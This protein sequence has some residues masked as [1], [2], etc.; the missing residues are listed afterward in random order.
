MASLI[1]WS[2]CLKC[3]GA[4][5]IDAFKFAKADFKLRGPGGKADSLIFPFCELAFPGFTSLL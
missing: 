3:R 5:A 4:R 1:A 2:G